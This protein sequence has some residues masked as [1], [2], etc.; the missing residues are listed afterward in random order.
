VLAVAVGGATGIYRIQGVVSDPP[1]QALPLPPPSVGLLP[2]AASSSH[3]GGRVATAA[4]MTIEDLFDRTSFSGGR[5]RGGYWAQKPNGFVLHGM[6]DVPGV[7]LS[8]AIHMSSGSLTGPPAI[9]G[10]PTVR[11]RLAGTLTL[12]GL[13][14]SGRVGRAP[15]HA[16]LAA[17]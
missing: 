14:L 8:G 1:D 5:P 9:S 6:I 3:V 12:H 4:A 7:A 10:R 16:R 11:G 13:A 15:V 2:A 17:L